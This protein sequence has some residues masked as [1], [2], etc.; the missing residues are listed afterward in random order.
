MQDKVD[1]VVQNAV[2]ASKAEFIRE[3]HQMNQVYS[4]IRIKNFNV[5]FP[6]LAYNFIL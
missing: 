1:L 5:V 6:I 3:M 4:I 2:A